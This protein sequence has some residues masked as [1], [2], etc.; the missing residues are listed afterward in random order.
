MFCTWVLRLNKHNITMKQF[1]RSTDTCHLVQHNG[2]RPP[3]H[4]NLS[5]EYNISF[6]QISVGL[7][8]HKV[9]EIRLRST[10]FVI[11]SLMWLL[12]W[13]HMT[14]YH[15]KWFFFILQLT[16]EFQSQNGFLYWTKQLDQFFPFF[17]FTTDTVHVNMYTLRDNTL[18]WLLKVTNYTRYW[19]FV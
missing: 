14:C 10:V 11:F 5:I 18:R 8:E 3:M 15:Q 16:V 13:A 9:D 1:C 2:G 19:K 4:R 6:S 7:N 12:F 17:F